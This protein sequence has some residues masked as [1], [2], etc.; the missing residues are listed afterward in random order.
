[1]FKLPLSDPITFI[2]ISK[3]LLEVTRRV[4]FVPK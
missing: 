4:K 1:M 2:A 3:K